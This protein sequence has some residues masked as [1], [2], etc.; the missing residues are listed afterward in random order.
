VSEHGDF[1][2]LILTHDRFTGKPKK[3]AYCRFEDI[4][5]EHGDLN[6]KIIE[7]YG[8]NL[9]TLFGKTEDSTNITYKSDDFKYSD[10]FDGNSEVYADTL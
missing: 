3:N 8:L 4:S 6:P 10:F 9:P 1:I 7:F 2:R 5:S